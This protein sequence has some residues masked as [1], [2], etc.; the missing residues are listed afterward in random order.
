MDAL[1]RRPIGNGIN[2]PKS[3]G[4]EG[5]S[6]DA[7]GES[8]ART[9][10]YSPRPSLLVLT[11]GDAATQ[12]VHDDAAAL[13]YRIADVA[14]IGAA[15][16]RLDRH[17]G[18]DAVVVEVDCDPGPALDALLDC[19]E[20][21][22]RCGGHGSVVIAPPTLLDAVAARTP[23]PRIQHLCAPLPSDRVAALALAALAPPA[24]LHDIRRRQG[25]VRLQ[26]LSEEI[27]RIA[28][29]LASL[30]EAEAIEPA[31]RHAG[32]GEGDHLVGPAEIR[33]VLRA[34]RM[35]DRYFNGDFFADP[36]WD[37]MLDLLAARLE[38]QRVAVSSLCIAAAVP[39]TT[40][41]R[42]IKLLSE[43]GLFVRSA[44]PQDGRRVYIAL[45]DE[46]AASLGAY[47]RAVQRLSP[48]VI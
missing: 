40:A 7:G 11:D 42:W 19:L 23:H 24:R 39:P 3:G 46:A 27:G 43:H 15:L 48:L 35:R 34:R 6:L 26:Q 10:E 29:L 4:P 38:G 22:A 47:L 20:A 30:S 32:E 1:A 44:D 16:S 31:P 33:A 17:V 13:G 41:L 28:S 14:P 2:R 21:R 18:P 37:M 45:S 8:Q 36:A 5:V 12:R 9:L 25:P